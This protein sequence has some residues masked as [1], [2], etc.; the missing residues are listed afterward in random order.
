M[1]DQ[2]QFFISWEK[3][4]RGPQVLVIFSFRVSKGT[5]SPNLSL[6]NWKFSQAVSSF[7]KFSSFIN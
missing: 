3:Y 1:Y 2:R 4:V 5:G 7:P 6:V